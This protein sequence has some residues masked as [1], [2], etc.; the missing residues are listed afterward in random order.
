MKLIN[1]PWLTLLES[2]QLQYCNLY[3]DTVSFRNALPCIFH[4][5]PKLHSSVWWLLQALSELMQGLSSVL[6]QYYMCTSWN[7][8]SFLCN[9]MAVV[10]QSTVWQELQ[11]STGWQEYSYHLYLSCVGSGLGS[12]NADRVVRGAFGSWGEK[13]FEF[14]TAFC[15]LFS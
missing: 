2:C 8:Y 6:G 12:D 13:L 10:Q 9:S 5:L 1:N 11:G 15:Q 4:L 14:L 3:G 7:W